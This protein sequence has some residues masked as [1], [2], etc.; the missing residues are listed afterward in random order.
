MIEAVDSDAPN[1]AH[2][3]RRAGFGMNERAHNDCLKVLR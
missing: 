3:L 1:C 2:I